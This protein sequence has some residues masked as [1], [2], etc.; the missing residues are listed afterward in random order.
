MALLLRHVINSLY[1]TSLFFL[2]QT[3]LAALTLDDVRAAMSAYQDAVLRQCCCNN[4]RGK[5]GV[6]RHIGR[7]LQQLMAVA[8]SYAVLHERLKQLRE[9][10]VKVRGECCSG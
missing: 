10:Y 7:A 9:E 2:L 8:M 4:L 5:G 6:W 3:L 1:C